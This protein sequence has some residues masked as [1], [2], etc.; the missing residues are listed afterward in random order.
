MLPN[1]S[2]VAAADFSWR[3]AKDENERNVFHRLQKNPAQTNRSVTLCWHPL[4]Q[5][6]LNDILLI[7][8][9]TDIR[10]NWIIIIF[11]PLDAVLPMYTLN[12]VSV[13]PSVTSRV[14]SKRLNGSSC[15]YGGKSE[16]LLK[17]TYGNIHCKYGNT[18]DDIAPEAPPALYH[19]W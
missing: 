10:C 7:T 17:V 15:K 5:W 14:L 2:T 16:G 18:K 8:N 3:W 13:C 6:G 12:P 9:S 11:Y 4:H 1:I 19:L